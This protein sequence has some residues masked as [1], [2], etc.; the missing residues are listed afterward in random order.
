MASAPS[1][2]IDPSRNPPITPTTDP[3]GPKPGIRTTEFWGAQL[4]ALAQAT[5]GLVVAFGGHVTPAQET[6]ILA[7]I[8]IGITTVEA[9]YVL[10]RSWVK[11]R[12]CGG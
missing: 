7:A 11:V 3:Q 2:P 10:G 4:A 9:A 5:F 6:A 1:A 12:T 8:P